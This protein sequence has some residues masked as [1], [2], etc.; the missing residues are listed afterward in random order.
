MQ[1]LNLRAGLL[2]ALDQAKKN[3]VLGRDAVVRKTMLDECKGDRLEEVLAVFSSAVVKRRA[4]EDRLNAHST[5]AVAQTWALQHR[6]YSAEQTELNVMVLAHT[7]SLSG[8]LREKEKSRAKYQDFSELLDLKQRSISRRREQIRV[9]SLVRLGGERPEPLPI[10]KQAVRRA[11]RN[12]WSGNEGWA[13]TLLHGD[14]VSRRDGL[15]ATSYDRVWRRVES[16]RLTELEDRS[17]TLL[18]QLDRR[19]RVQRERL[20]GWEDFCTQWLGTP[21]TRPVHPAGTPIP[22]KR[23]IDFCFEAHQGLRPGRPSPQKL[24]RPW[25]T[26]LH[27][28]YAALVDG[29]DSELRRIKQG[30]PGIAQA[31]LRFPNTPAQEQMSV[32]VAEEEPVSELSEL[33]EEAVRAPAPSREKGE[34]AGQQQKPVTKR[35]RTDVVVTQEHPTRPQRTAEPQEAPL[36]LQGIDLPPPQQHVQS[37]PPPAVRSAVRTPSPIHRSPVQ[38]PRPQADARSSPPPV[39]PTQKIADQILASMSN[40][41][42]SPPKKPRHTLSLAERTRLSMARVARATTFDDDDESDIMALSIGPAP[43]VMSAGG[44]DKL[45]MLG[46]DNGPPAG[47]HEDLVARTRKS[48]AGFEAARQKAQLERRRSQRRSRHPPSAAASASRREGSAY[49]SVAE[50]GN[51]TILAEELASGGQEDAEAIFKSRPKIRNSPVT[52]PEKDWD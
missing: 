16:G 47:S 8:L 6:S 31:A 22:K 27:G 21:G 35:S 50:E 7:V 37:R 29:L 38:H 15:L 18:E 45:A 33:D 13:E 23:G 17:A 24:A 39:S 1:S 41:S 49:L 12:N 10:D 19:V 34:E 20:Q 26:S 52:S 32:P 48:M 25:T 14:A 36:R 46:T 28:D 4:A 51:S 2:R 9:P 3:G 11:V 44:K 5:P 30:S 42:P 43:N 40:T